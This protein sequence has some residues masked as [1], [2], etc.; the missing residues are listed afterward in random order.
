MCVM[1]GA[2]GCEGVWLC[3]GG[4]C[5]CWWLCVWGAQQLHTGGAMMAACD[6]AARGPAQP[7]LTFQL[8]LYIVC[9]LPRPG[10]GV[11]RMVHCPSQAG[12]QHASYHL[13]GPGRLEPV[14][15]ASISISIGCS[16]PCPPLPMSEEAPN[17]NALLGKGGLC[18]V[19][20][21]LCHG[22]SACLPA[23]G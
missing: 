10:G 21:C 8:L 13:L 17:H 6:S 20:V 16:L 12:F 14:P 3:G 18:A 1:G 7:A 4:R 9:D 22:G 19:Q 11:V 2:G 5:V 23:F 15:Q